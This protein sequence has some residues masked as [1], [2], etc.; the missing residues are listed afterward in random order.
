MRKLFVVALGFLWGL[1]AS[2]QPPVLIAIYNFDTAYVGMATSSTGSVYRSYM[3]PLVL[4]S[5]GNFYNVGLTAVNGG[6]FAAGHTPPANSRS[7]IGAGWLQTASLSRSMGFMLAPIAGQTL[8]VDRIDY[9]SARSN[10]GPDSTQW[11]TNVGG[12]AA[13]SWRGVNTGSLLWEFHSITSGLPSSMSQID[14]RFLTYHNVLFPNPSG[15]WRI[16]DVRVYGHLE[17]V[18]N[19]PVELTSF[20]GQAVRE[21]VELEWRT[22]SETNND[23]FTVFRSIDTENWNKVDTV[24]G[25]GN[26]QTEIRYGLLDEDPA[27]GVNYYR[28]H[29]TD[30]NGDSTVSNVMPVLYQQAFSIASTVGLPVSWY[31]LE[32]ILTGID[33]KIIEGPSREHFMSKPGIFLLYTQEGDAIKLIV[34]P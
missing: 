29:Q 32:T 22:A 14:I 33:G 1:K 17:N 27:N 19:L 13:N 4:S 12:Y 11:R 28:L 10:Q 34:T 25:A 26:S 23:Y 15:T 30:F 21:G 3:N 9:W 6:F 31:G 24:N 20:S 8:V 5:A 18:Y 16:D 2:A 7:R